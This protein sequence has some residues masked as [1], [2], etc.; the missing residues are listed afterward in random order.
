MFVPARACTR[1]CHVTSHRASRPS[2]LCR[3]VILC[4]RRPRSRPMTVHLHMWAEL[5]PQGTMWPLWLQGLRV[6]LCPG[7]MLTPSPCLSRWLMLALPLHRARQSRGLLP[8]TE[9]VVAALAGPRHRYRPSLA[10]PDHL[11]GPAVPQ[12]AAPFRLLSPVE[13][14]G[15]RLHWPPACALLSLNSLGALPRGLSGLAPPHRSEGLGLH[16]TGS[17]T[18]SPAFL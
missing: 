4:P 16:L 5:C 14:E 3:V 8:A 9:T 18:T 1:L 17:L 6:C 7:A 13:A 10:C 15:T 12:A 11:V 2:V